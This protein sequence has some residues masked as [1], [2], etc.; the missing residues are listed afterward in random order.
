MRNSKRMLNIHDITKICKNDYI[1][2]EN[3]LKT[4][5]HKMNIGKEINNFQNYLIE[6]K[7]YNEI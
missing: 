1:V 7:Q 2:I 4:I 6:E 5:E 3:V